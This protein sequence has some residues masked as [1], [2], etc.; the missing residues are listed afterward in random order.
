MTARLSPVAGVASPES[1]QRVTPKELAARY[2][3]TE[4]WWRSRLG[5]LTALGLLNKIGRAHWGRPARIEAW[6]AGEV[7]AK[8][9]RGAA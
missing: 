9:T 4:R 1:P 3:S 6:L 7:P 2:G 5:E 8:R